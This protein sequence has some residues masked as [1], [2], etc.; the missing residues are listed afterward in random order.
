M[1]VSNRVIV[2]I[3]VIITVITKVLFIHYY[4]EKSNNKSEVLWKESFE[5]MIAFI[6]HGVGEGERLEGCSLMKNL[7]NKRVGREVYTKTW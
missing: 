5:Y 3:G 6:E 1:I 4:L 2:T 7:Y